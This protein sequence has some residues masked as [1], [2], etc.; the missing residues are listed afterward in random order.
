MLCQT[1]GQLGGPTPAVPSTSLP[2]QKAGRDLGQGKREIGGKHR[3]GLERE[4]EK[5][6]K[7]ERK[8]NL[9]MG[10]DPGVKRKLEM[11]S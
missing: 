9:G 5:E 2:T 8:E 10:F 4:R 6:S 1:L 7:G 3:K 11:V